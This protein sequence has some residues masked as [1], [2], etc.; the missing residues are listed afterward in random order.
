MSSDGG[1]FLSL[2]ASL[3]EQSGDVYGKNASRA[4][5]F[6]VLFAFAAVVVPVAVIAIIAVLRVSGAF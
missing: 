1:F 3:K 5:F 6:Y 4:L 2:F